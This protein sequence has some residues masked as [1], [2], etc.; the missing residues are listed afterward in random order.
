MLGYRRRVLGPTTHAVRPVGVALARA[1][2]APARS[3]PGDP[4]WVRRLDELHLLTPLRI[5]TIIVVAL[6]V[7]LAVR[8]VVDRLLRRTFVLPGT[9]PERA[10]ARRRAL[11]S[12]LRSS[13]FGLIWAAAVITVISEVGI[14]IGAFVATA[15]VIGGAV[16]FG[17]QT[18]VRDVISGFF[19][20]A[21]DQYG[22][23]DSVDLG[24]ATGVVERI[25]LRSVRLRDAEG[26]IWYV[27]HGGVARVGNLSKTTAV[28]LTM[29]VARQSKLADLHR[30]ASTLGERLTDV[31]GG[32]LTAPPTVVGLVDLADDRIVYQ[33]AAQ[34]HPGRQ[35]EVRR[36]WRALV[37]GA[38]E[39][40]ELSPPALPA[41]IVGDDLDRTHDGATPDAGQGRSVTEP[42]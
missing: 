8:V 37:L 5:V 11:A 28:Q 13:L 32:R 41:T 25:T 39:R 17:A 10:D 22:T 29:H 36:A 20:L 15:T 26:K 42:E 30:V 40:G 35:D 1:A 2:F 38:F 16:A 9:D 33:V 27:P 21:E 18:L 3:N 4:Q 31:V 6:L 7:T 12:A 24:L 14:N 19:V 23:G 34:I